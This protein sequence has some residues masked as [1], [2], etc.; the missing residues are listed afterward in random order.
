[1]EIPIRLKIPK[2]L[3]P[4]L[5][6]SLVALWLFLPSPSIFRRISAR[7]NGLPEATLP[8]RAQTLDVVGR[9][10]KYTRQE[11]E[12][13][14]RES[15]RK[16]GLPE[17]KV[18]RIA[19]CESKLDPNVVSKNRMFWGLYQFALATWNNTPEGKAK[20]DRLDPVANITAAHRHMKTHGY[21]AW[22]HCKSR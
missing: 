7:G 20:L 6:G 5:A 19:I 2:S 12:T 3:F 4:R 1:M 14:I 17:D 11:I 9:K 13:L 15:A 8:S 18:L 10:R 21:G 22:P 16:H